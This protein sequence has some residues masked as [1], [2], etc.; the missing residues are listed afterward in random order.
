M[1]IKVV[2]KGTT[3]AKPNGYCPTLI[4]DVTWGTTK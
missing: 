4:D 1:K 3:N 2:K